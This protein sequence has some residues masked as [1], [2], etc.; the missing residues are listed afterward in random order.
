MT[1][2]LA[3]FRDL[4]LGGAALAVLDVLVV[5]VIVYRVLLLLRGSRGAHVLVGLLAVA[6]IVLAA[7]QLSLV[8]LTWLLDHVLNYLLLI[9]I[10]VFQADIRRG[11]MRMGRKVF[12]AARADE[13]STVLEEV[14]AACE[15]MAARRIG[16]LIVFEREVDLRELTQAGT[17]LDAVVSKELLL[18]IFAP[19]A[20][21]ALHDGAVL[22]QGSRLKRA[23]A[24]LPLSSSQRLDKSF[25][26][27]HR[28]GLGVTEETDAISVVVSEQRGVVSL[29]QGGALRLDL[30]RPELRRE[31]RA[32]LA[33]E[34]ARPAETWFARWVRR[35]GRAMG[36]QR[37]VDEATKPAEVPPGEGLALAAPGDETAEKDAREATGNAKAGH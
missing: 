13:D 24:L 28:A 27:R 10:I 18:A 37:A 15:A 7:R 26:T 1:E 8:T 36:T 9:L 20:D 33:G 12:S 31:L 17:E 29:C 25:G 23:G 11:L 14:A 6:G 2:L 16:A 4:D 22:I 3:F 32:R 19:Q 21:N 34:G 5:A 35:L 30:S